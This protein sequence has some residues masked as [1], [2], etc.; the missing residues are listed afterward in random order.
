MGLITSGVAFISAETAAFLPVSGGFIR[1]YS[2]TITAT[3]LMSIFLGHIPMFTDRA[4][5]ITVSQA[6]T[7]SRLRSETAYR[8]D[9]CS[10]TY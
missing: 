1:T 2:N 4:L 9:G 10:G 7:R 8:W 6:V 3:Y 5:G